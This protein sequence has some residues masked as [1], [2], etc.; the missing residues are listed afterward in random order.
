MRHNVKQQLEKQLAERFQKPK[1]TG[2]KSRLLKGEEVESLLTKQ[3]SEFSQSSSKELDKKTKDAVVA[4]NKRIDAVLA[5]MQSVVQKKVDDMP[6]PQDGRTPTREEITAAL[7]PL[8]DETK[9]E[10]QARLNKIEKFLE[11]PKDDNGIPKDIESLEALIKSKVPKTGGGS[12]LNYF[13]ELLDT[14]KKVAGL[15]GAY[16]GYEGQVVTVSADGKS[17]VFAAGG[18]GDSLPDQTGNSGKFLT[19]DLSLIHI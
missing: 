1:R 19:T 16:Q 13:H 6:V 14:P 18:G 5:Y 9:K 7:L 11:A 4:L 3:F 15:R 8:V 12:N 2:M 17:L 10:Y